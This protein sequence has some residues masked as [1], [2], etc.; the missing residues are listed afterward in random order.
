MRRKH[1]ESRSTRETVKAREEEDEEEG[2]GKQ[3]EVLLCPATRGGSVTARPNRKHRQTARR[4]ESG[5][6]ER[7]GEEEE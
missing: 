5:D 6:E 4:M 3:R 1:N 2:S 7:P